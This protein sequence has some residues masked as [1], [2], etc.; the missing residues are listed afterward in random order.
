MSLRCI[1]YRYV[2]TIAISVLKIAYSK[3]VRYIVR[4]SEK[5]ITRLSKPC[6]FN[7]GA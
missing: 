3:S 7:G 2:M 1:D 5:K 6:D 4:L